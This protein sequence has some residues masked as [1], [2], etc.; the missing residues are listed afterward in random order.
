[1]IPRI[2][3]IFR[4]MIWDIISETDLDD[5]VLI[6][7]SAQAAARYEAGDRDA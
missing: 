6:K 7:I 4:D 1:M 2:K 5:A 3:M